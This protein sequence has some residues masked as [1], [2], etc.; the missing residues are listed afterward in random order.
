MKKLYTLQFVVF[1]YG[2]GAVHL[3]VGSQL[4]SEG[5]LGNSEEFYHELRQD[6]DTDVSVVKMNNLRQA[7]TEFEYEKDRDGRCLTWCRMREHTKKLKTASED[8][9]DPLVIN[10]LGCE[11][12][13][14]TQTKFLQNSAISCFIGAE[15]VGCSSLCC[16]GTTLIAG[17]TIVGAASCCCFY[18]TV[19]FLQTYHRALLQ[20]AAKQ[21]Y[22]GVLVDKNIQCSLEPYKNSYTMIARDGQP[23]HCVL[24]EMRR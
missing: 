16:Q 12:Q 14:V 15:A 2:V 1:L 10:H 20:L 18:Y 5:L 9:L 13:W 11:E 6:S 17:G 24:H 23:V 4:E 8:A 22:L 3:I 21:M 19:E 7:I